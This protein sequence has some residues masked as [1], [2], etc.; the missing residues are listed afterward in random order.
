MPDE[1]NLPQVFQH[2]QPAPTTQAGADLSFGAATAPSDEISRWSMDLPADP[3]EADAFLA[4]AEAQLR[5]TQALLEAAPQ[6]LESF[7]TRLESGAQPHYA[8]GAFPAGAAAEQPAEAVLLSWLDAVQPGQIAFGGE[9]LAGGQVGEAV[10]Q[11]QQVVNNLLGQLLHLAQVETRLQGQLLASSLVSWKGDV[12][13]TWGEGTQA[14][15]RSLHQRSLALALASRIA[16]LKMYTT[17]TQGA[18]KIAVLVAAP[19]GALLALPAAW[20]YLNILLS[21]I[22]NSSH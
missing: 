2:W 18:A 16:M 12:D 8:L 14:E 15:E 4:Q 9:G 20:K 19:G 1:L 7:I 11:F 21:Q 13:T 22:R 3:G 10:A 17:V 5:A 6:Q